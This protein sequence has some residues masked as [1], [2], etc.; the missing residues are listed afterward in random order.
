M[1]ECL[2]GL[3]TCH[4]T[5]QC[6]NTDGGFTC[7]CP[8]AA[9]LNSSRLETEYGHPIGKSNLLESSQ[10]RGSAA[11]VT[12]KNESLSSTEQI[13]SKKTPEINDTCLLSTFER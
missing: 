7:S 12:T 1:D 11:A 10:F 6:D 3:A 4:S 13:S 8:A 9:A 5:S 2:S